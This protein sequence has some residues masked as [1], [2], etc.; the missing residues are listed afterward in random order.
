MKSPG[1]ELAT[2][3]SLLSTL[4]FA[5]CTEPTK[6]IKKLNIKRAA[7]YE[8]IVAPATTTDSATVGEATSDAIEPP[9]SA[10]LE[11][12][13]VQGYRGECDSSFVGINEDGLVTVR[14]G[15][16]VR[17][18]RLA[19]I[20]IPAGVRDEAHNQIRRWLDKK[21]MSV[22]VDDSVPSLDVAAYLH[23]CPDGLMINEELVRVG[24]AVPSE[25]RFRRTDALKK[26]S[27]EALT[28]RRGVWGRS[29]Q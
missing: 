2:A 26:A 18:H 23:L 22:E 1:L 29:S 17:T 4:L 15:A 14:T 9:A 28:A 8:P 19:G 20:S 21:N 24:L 7:D 16:Q 5:A 6:P 3:V 10:P 13:E 27:V 11:I 12:V 25:S